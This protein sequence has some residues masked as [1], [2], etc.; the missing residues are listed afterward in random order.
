MFVV[1]AAAAFIS[2]FLQISLFK[3]AGEKLTRR[4][5]NM[6]FR[7]IL[8]QEIG[9]FDDEK[10]ST[11]VLTT[12]LAEDANLVQGMTGQTFGALIQAF[13]SLVAGLT[14]AFRSSWQLTLG[15]FSDIHFNFK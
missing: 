4:L 3:Y 5:R 1:L 13:A 6:Y 15:M 12:R 8:R 14:I 11:G 2:N 10:N 7:A 9:F